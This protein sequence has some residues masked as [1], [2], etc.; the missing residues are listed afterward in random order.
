MF[1]HHSCIISNTSLVGWLAR[2]PIWEAAKINEAQ[3]SS[4]KKH[5]SIDDGG[6]SSPLTFRNILDELN[7]G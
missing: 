5:S 7:L 1:T 4:N 3:F 2:I 6:S